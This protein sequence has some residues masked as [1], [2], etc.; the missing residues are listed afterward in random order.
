MAAEPAFQVGCEVSG[1]LVARFWITFETAYTNRLQIPIERWYQR[2]QFGRL[3]FRRLANHGNR[4]GT[5]EWWTSG[6]HV[7]Q[8]C[9]ETV[10]IGS[11]GK[12]DGCVTGLFGGNKTCGSQRC[13]RSRKVVVRVQQLRQTEIADQWLASIIE[14]NVSRFDIAMEHSA[15]V[16]VF[17]STRDLC[18]QLH[19]L[20]GFIAER[21]R[22]LAQTSFLGEL[23]AEK[24][25]AV[26][27][28]AHFINRKDVRVIQ[29]GHR[30][31]LSSETLQ[32]SV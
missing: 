29:T 14:Q 31:C 27:A 3:R 24:R 20:P 22:V 4:I 25:Q 32:R 21:G 10:N 2:A 8:N 1:G 9:A 13:Q 26:L 19:A 7:E 16:S 11:W 6:K 23:H 12:I 18:H 30:L 28:F 17:D 5:Q 15:A